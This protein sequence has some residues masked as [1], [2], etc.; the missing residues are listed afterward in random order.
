M[1]KFAFF[2]MALA[3]AASML[4]GCGC[5]NTDENVTTLPTNGETSAPPTRAT[6]APTT[7]PTTVPATTEAPTE[8]SSD[9]TDTTGML[10]GA[11]DDI[12]GGSTD[13]ANTGNGGNSGSGV[14]GG[15]DVGRGRSFG[16]GPRK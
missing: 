1:K 4:V 10:E 13:D 7:M 6:T 16:N 15:A 5:M 12:V 8:E 11:V 2:T 3:L 14:N 9:P